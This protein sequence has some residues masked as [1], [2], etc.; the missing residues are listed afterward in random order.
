MIR[1]Y[2]IWIADLN[3]RVGTEPGK[4]RP[5]VVIQSDLL[6]EANHP[7]TIICPIST[8]LFES[9][10]VLRVRIPSGTASFVQNCE[11]LVDQIRAIDNNRFI[12][13]IGTLPDSISETLSHNIR[14]IL[15]RPMA[16]PFAYS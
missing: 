14:I 7:S 13:K 2:D 4:Q 15:D 16:S 5:V 10:S 3:P 8:N 12:R 6:N 9:S 1:Q 11:I